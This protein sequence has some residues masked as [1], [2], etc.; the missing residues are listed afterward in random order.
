MPKN[1]VFK[2]CN[3]IT[4]KKLSEQ[5]V[6]AYGHLPELLQWFLAREEKHP[7]ENPEMLVRSREYEQYRANPEMAN[8][9][10]LRAALGLTNNPYYNGR[11]I[12]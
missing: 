10:L 12:E 4:D 8:L 5:E 3:I 6:T 9:N 11:P 7:G 2:G 1:L